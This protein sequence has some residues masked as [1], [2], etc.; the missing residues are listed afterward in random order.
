MF[1]KYF[2]NEKLN[3]NELELFKRIIKICKLQDLYDIITPV[4][5]EIELENKKVRDL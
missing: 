1:K 3:E 5:Q 4:L 2:K